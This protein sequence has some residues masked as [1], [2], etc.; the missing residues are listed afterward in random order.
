MTRVEARERWEALQSNLRQARTAFAAGD[1]L[2][3]LEKIDAALEI[4]P[5]YLAAQSLRSQVLARTDWQAPESADSG[6]PIQ[7]QQISAEG[8]AR[9][10]ERARDRRVQRRLEA[11]HAAIAGSRFEDAAAAVD[12]LRELR[13][14]LVDLPALSRAIARGPAPPSSSPSSRSSRLKIAVAII[15]IVVLAAWSLPRGPVRL[16]LPRI[17]PSLSTIVELPA[18]AVEETPRATVPESVP[19]AT[20]AE[21]TSQPRVLDTEIVSSSPIATVEPPRRQEIV[22]FAPLN[23]GNALAPAPVPADVPATPA[24]PPVTPPADAIVPTPATVAVND[25]QLVREA[26]QKYRWAYEE[27]SAASA[28]DIWP[29]VDEAALARAF[30]GL[31]SQSLTFQDC[32][33]EIEGLAATATCRGTTQYVPKVGSR[34]PRV[35]PRRWNFSLRKRGAGW[36]IENARAER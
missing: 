29:G 8:Y 16:P 26:L 15:A 36:Q 22:A 7:P 11:A 23:P 34:V 1:R 19:V 3:A 4:D 10:E 33:V 18:P 13:P 35:E 27:L 25:E 21:S 12:E 6:K 9:F 28:H 32:A 31:A 24:P 20:S 17:L 14:G 30:D 5:Q 2:G